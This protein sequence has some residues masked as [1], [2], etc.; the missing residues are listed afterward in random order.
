MIVHK[1]GKATIRMRELAE[2]RY[3][4]RKFLR[5]SEEAATRAGLTP[6][7]HQ[8]MLQVAGAPEGTVVSVGYIAERLALRHHSVVELSKRCEDAG[9]IV[10]NVAQSEHRHVLL[11]LTA[12]G[13]RLLQSLSDDH[14]NELYSLGSK[15]VEA[16]EPF[17]KCPR[18]GKA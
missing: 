14:A 12:K 2:F 13:D 1:A 10:R 4:V 6:Q 11:S 18:K 8:L 5:F 17:T 3:T 9:Y 16:L 15:L 7:K